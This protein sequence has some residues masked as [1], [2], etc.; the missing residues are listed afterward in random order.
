MVQATLKSCIK[1]NKGNH[2]DSFS[3]L[4]VLDGTYWIAYRT[5]KAHVSP[6]GKIVL[7]KSR[8][9]AE[10]Q[11][12]ARLEKNGLDCRD[13]RLAV[14]DGRLHLLFFTLNHH[15]PGYPDF[16]ASD[17]YIYR[18]NKKGDSIEQVA[19]LEYE[20]LQST[21]WALDKIDGNYYAIGYNYLHG[22]Y[23]SRLFKAADIAGPWTVVSRISDATLPPDVGINEVDL[24]V[25]D[26]DSMT[27]FCRCD[28]DRFKRL[29]KDPRIHEEAAR[30]QKERIARSDI[31]PMNDAFCDWIAVARSNP[32]YTEW[33]MST[34]RLWLKGPRAIS[35]GDD[36]LFVGRFSRPGWMFKQVNLYHY[37]GEFHELL[38][39]AGGMD[40]SYAGLAWN[41]DEP[42]ELLVSFYSD[43][44]R[45]GT[46]HAGQANDIWFARVEIKKE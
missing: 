29:A 5:G 22:H 31:P 38:E 27:C 10:W 32:P 12:V 26:D 33:R 7:C 24:V 43:H 3:D 34:H 11:E 35:F 8:D 16:K 45:F 20:K 15:H 41:P 36:Y 9:G 46:F 17:S 37:D 40:G 1:V 28:G 44:A 6:A 30:M 2:Y 23:E 13:P 21:F 18:A 19:T 14:I 42:S 25:N 39:L 4:K